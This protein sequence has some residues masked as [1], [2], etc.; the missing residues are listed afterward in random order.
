MYGHAQ[1]QI[2]RLGLVCHENPAHSG[3]WS[4]VMDWPLIGIHSVVLSDG[5]VLTYGANAA[6]SQGALEYDVWDPQAGTAQQSHNYVPGVTCLLYTSPSPRD[7]RQSRMPS[8]A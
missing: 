2:E 4:S 6:G 8:S 5:R 1:S 3:R 7:K